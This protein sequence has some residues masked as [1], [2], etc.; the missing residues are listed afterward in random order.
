MAIERGER[1]ASADVITLVLENVKRM[2][3]R[4]QADELIRQLAP[5]L[6]AR[7]WAQSG[8]AREER[9]ASG[10]AESIAACLGDDAAIL[11][12]FYANCELPPEIADNMDDA[13]RLLSYAP[14]SLV[15]VVDL[16]TMI[17]GAPVS[18]SVARDIIVPTLQVYE[19]V[20]AMGKRPID[21]AKMPPDYWD[22]GDR[23]EHGLAAPAARRGHGGIA[24][25]HC[26]EETWYDWNGA[27][28]NPESDGPAVWPTCPV[29]KDTMLTVRFRDGEQR[30]TNDPLLMRWAWSRPY[31]S[32]ADIVAFKI[33][34]PF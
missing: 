7:G 9:L 12:G 26:E 29:Y 14:L 27:R 3:V 4:M 21:V 2:D 30:R 16:T 32:Q 11:R 23:P 13:A 24:P 34:S 25:E 6:K 19:A 17:W 18:L 5:Y 20:R 15:E 28:L 22:A 10:N 31:V 1:D 8:V 33:E